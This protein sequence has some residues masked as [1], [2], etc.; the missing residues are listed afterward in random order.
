MA[1]VTSSRP[2]V[3]TAASLLVAADSDG[4]RVWIHNPNSTGCIIGGS[5]VTATTGLNLDSAAGPKEFIL[6]PLAELWGIVPVTTVTVQLLV[7][8]NR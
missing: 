1:F 3:T 8:G 5:D 6:P 2:S 4:C 7:I